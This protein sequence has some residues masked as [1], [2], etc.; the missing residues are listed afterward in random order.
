MNISFENKVDSLQAQDLDWV[1]RR[2]GLLLNQVL[3]W[4]WRLE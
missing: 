2:P 3:P 4:C 1:L